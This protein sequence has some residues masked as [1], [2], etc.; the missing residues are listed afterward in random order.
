MDAGDAAQTVV[1]VR[2][3]LGDALNGVLDKQTLKSNGY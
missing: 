2:H 3:A 1:E